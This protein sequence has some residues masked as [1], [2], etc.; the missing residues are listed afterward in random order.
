MHYTRRFLI[1][2][3][4]QVKSSA[5]GESKASFYDAGL[6][7]FVCI[8]VAIRGLRSLNLGFRRLS[9]YVWI[10]MVTS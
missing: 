4:V 2:S 3:V 9:A 1:I 6:I 10:A 7:V 8:G 5:A